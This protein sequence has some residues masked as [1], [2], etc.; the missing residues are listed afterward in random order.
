VPEL[1]AH[2][3]AHTDLRL[4]AITDHD[5]IAGAPLATRLT[6]DTGGEL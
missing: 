1:L 4:I 5:S 3:A 2:V 6:S